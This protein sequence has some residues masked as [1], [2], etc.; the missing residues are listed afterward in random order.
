MNNKVKHVQSDEETL[1]TAIAKAF[2]SVIE[3]RGIPDWVA[4]IVKEKQQRSF[5]E[6]IGRLRREYEICRYEAASWLPIPLIRWEGY[7][8]AGGKVLIDEHNRLHPLD[9]D[10]YAV[11]RGYDRML[12]RD[13]G[14]DLAVEVLI[15]RDTDM[16]D[17][18]R[19]LEKILA[20]IR[21]CTEVSTCSE[22]EK[23]ESPT[24]IRCS[25]AQRLSRPDPSDPPF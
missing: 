14:R 12:L 6:S 9:G 24:R 19:L 8:A 16:E 18:I 22:P 15:H 5:D 13:Q 23:A 21:D 20:D 4:D 11:G 7:A 1:E 2:P 17:A 3:R 25:I 10:G